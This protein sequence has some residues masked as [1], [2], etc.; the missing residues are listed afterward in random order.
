MTCPRCGDRFD[1][2]RVGQTRCPRCE[3]EVRTLID[4]DEKRRAPRFRVA[5]DLTGR[6]A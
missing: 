4:L 3:R 2:T 5:K 1:M 6:A